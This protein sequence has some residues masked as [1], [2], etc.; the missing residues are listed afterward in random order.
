MCYRIKKL[1]FKKFIDRFF[2]NDGMDDYDQLSFLYCFYVGVIIFVVIN[3]ICLPFYIE[4]P[5][6]AVTIFGGLSAISFAV[7]IILRLLTISETGWV[8]E[9]KLRSLIYGTDEF[10]NILCLCSPRFL[11]NRALYIGL[12]IH[13]KPGVSHT[14]WYIGLYTK[15]GFICEGKM[16]KPEDIKYWAIPPETAVELYLKLDGFLTDFEDEQLLFMESG[17]KALNKRR[18]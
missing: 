2:N 9:D 17:S 3:F 5:T 18:V 15:K 14:E 12:N 4:Y 11:H 6:H 1:D 10:Y 7:F 13:D 16:Y 8:N